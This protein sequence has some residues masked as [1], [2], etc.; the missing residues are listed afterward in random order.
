MDD[1]DL[2]DQGKKANTSPVHK[3]EQSKQ[4]D[5]APKGS[6]GRSRGG[7]PALGL[8]PST[9]GRQRFQQTEGQSLDQGQETENKII[10]RRNP[11]QAQAKDDRPIAVETGVK[12]IDQDSKDKGF[13]LKTEDEIKK[14][15][16]PEKDKAEAKPERSGDQFRE[17][18][19]PKVN[20]FYQKTDDMISREEAI[21]K[22]AE[23]IRKSFE[24]HKSRDRDRER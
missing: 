19:D 15:G 4:Y 8:G 9:S 3:P 10:F 6:V 12:E 11:E 18:N 21:K 23:E 13:Q 16:H 17:T 24:N 2:G 5:V 14:L 22:R 1:D 7:L 20:E